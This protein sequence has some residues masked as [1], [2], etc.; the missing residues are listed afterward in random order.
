MKILALGHNKNL[1]EEALTL[2]GL[3][4]LVTEQPVSAVGLQSTETHSNA[5]RII[6]PLRFPRSNNVFGGVD[7][8]PQPPGFH[9]PHLLGGVDTAHYAIPTEGKFLFGGIG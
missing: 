9:W 3:A 4:R 5:R 7:G 8:Q 6:S 2:H 1:V